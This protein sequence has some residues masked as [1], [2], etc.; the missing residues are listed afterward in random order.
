MMI[1]FKEWTWENRPVG[2]WAH[3]IK[4][5][6]FTFR[7]VLRGRVYSGMVKKKKT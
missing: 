2:L 4:N 1:P 5:I 6:F 3:Q 7:G